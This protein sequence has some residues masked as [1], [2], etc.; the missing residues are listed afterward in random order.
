MKNDPFIDV[1][2]LFDEEQDYGH[3]ITQL[4]KCSLTGTSEAL[5]Q[6]MLEDTFVLNDI[7]ILGQWT[8]LY[9]SPNTGKTLLTLWLLRE[10]IDSGQIDS[11]KVFYINADDHYRG[12]VEKTELAE[13]YC[14]HMIAPHHKEFDV[15]QV[16]EMMEDMA[17]DG[18]ANGVVFI[19]DTLKKFTD[20]MNKQA[21]SDFGIAARAF[22]SAGGTLIALAHTNK[23]KDADGKGI[24]S[25]TSDIVDDSDCC[26]ILDKISETG[27]IHTVEFRNIKMRGDVASLAGFTYQ[28]HP[29]QSYMDLLNSVQRIEKEDLESSRT[30]ARVNEKLVE[31]QPIIKAVCEAIAGGINTKDKL[32]K[33]VQAQTGESSRRVKEVLE[34]RTGDMHMFGHRWTISKGTHNKHVYAALPSL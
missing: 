5:R 9:A 6:K 27:S 2:R 10:S 19:L 22:V 20:L 3:T 30:K 29:N 26:F 1:V 33:A 14:M 21:A 34:D 7:A 18:S 8:T 28:K 4:Q 16:P 32:V 23:H 12:L 24:Y 15:K 11:E 31:D 17:R 13:E 25:G